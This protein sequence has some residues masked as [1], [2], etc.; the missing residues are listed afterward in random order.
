MNFN[1]YGLISH[2]MLDR[3][4][5]SERGRYVINIKKEYRKFEIAARTRSSNE[6]SLIPENRRGP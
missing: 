5:Y 2:A 4:T 6:F 3:K 1:E